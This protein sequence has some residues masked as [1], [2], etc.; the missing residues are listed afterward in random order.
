MISL[1]KIARYTLVFGERGD[2][3]GRAS[4]RAVAEYQG[5][6]SPRMRVGHFNI[7]GIA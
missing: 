2:A 6:T 5:P 1:A 4:P 3:Q 7:A